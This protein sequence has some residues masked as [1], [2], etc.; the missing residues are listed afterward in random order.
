MEKLKALFSDR[1]M[2]IVFMMGFASGLPYLLTA[3]T[4][5]AWCKDAGMDLTTIGF[6]TLVTLPYSLKFLWAPV[7]DWIVPKGMGPGIGR[8]KA[9]LLISQ[10]GLIAALVGLSMTNPST[11]IAL[12]AIMAFFVCFMSATQDVVIDAYQIEYLPKEQYALGNQLYIIGYRIAMIVAG[13][14]TLMMTDVMSWKMVYLVM[15]A[16]M[17]LALVTTFFAKEPTIE[18]KIPRGFVEAVWE[19]LKDFFSTN[20]SHKGKALWILAFFLV[21]KLG[22]DM[23]SIA[24]TPFYMDLGFT[25]PIIGQMSKAVGLWATIGGGIAGAVGVV[26]FGIRRSLWAFG[27]FQGLACFSFVWLNSYVAGMSN[28]PAWALGISISFENVAVGMATA[29]FCAYMGSLVNRRYTAT[30]YAILSSLMSLPRTLA[31][32]FTLWTAQ[33]LGYSTLFVIC[34]S[35]SI[36]GLLILLKLRGVGGDVATAGASTTATAIASAATETPVRVIGVPYAAASET[37]AFDDASVGFVRVSGENAKSVG[38][39]DRAGENTL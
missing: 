18:G 14:G 15:A 3:S 24:S 39:N 7:M 19:P 8:R 9:W 34:A 4:L 23:A 28:P 11:N 33:T 29:A 6:F 20:G 32:P 30:Q 31:G 12:M 10:V 21:Y 2:F 13:A 35:A 36:P 22:A 38:G 27:I 17:G 5:Q 25:K 1:R 16:T 37:E 26:Y